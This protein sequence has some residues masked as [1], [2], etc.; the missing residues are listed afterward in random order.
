M[1]E[2]QQLSKMCSCDALF[3]YFQDSIEFGHDNFDTK[4]TRKSG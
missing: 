1:K 4:G 3:D 2:L